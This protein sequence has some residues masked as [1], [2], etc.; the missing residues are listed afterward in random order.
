MRRR[1][2]HVTLRSPDIRAPLVTPYP[3]KATR[4]KVALIHFDV[5]DDS[6]R[7]SAVIRILH[8]ESILATATTPTT[9]QIGTRHVTVRWHVPLHVI[10]PLQYCI[11]ATDPAG[12]HSQRACALFLRLAAPPNS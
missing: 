4:G 10:A 6:G 9:F 8:N 12:N 7:T 3:V 1:Q 5:Y 11:A 2:A